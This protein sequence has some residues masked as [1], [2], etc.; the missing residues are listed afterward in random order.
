MSEGA[1]SPYVPVRFGL[2][3]GAIQSSLAEES[4]SGLVRFAGPSRVNQLEAFPSLHGGR[5]DEA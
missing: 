4:S 3:P 5:D 2:A 1:L